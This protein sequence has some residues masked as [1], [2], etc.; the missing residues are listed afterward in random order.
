MSKISLTDEVEDPV[1][2][3]KNRKPIA[4]EAFEDNNENQRQLGFDIY[5]DDKIPVE[6]E[7]DDNVFKVQP[8]VAVRPAEHFCVY[9]DDDQ[10][11]KTE[12][13]KASDLAQALSLENCIKPVDESKSPFKKIQNVSNLNC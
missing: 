2:V 9:V 10:E 6:N 12:Q 1:L 11:V 3:M 4:F 13:P 8:Q 5:E 7:V